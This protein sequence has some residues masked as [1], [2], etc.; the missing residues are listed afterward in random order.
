MNVSERHQ[1]RQNLLSRHTSYT[2][3]EAISVAC[4]VHQGAVS[5]N[6]LLTLKAVELQ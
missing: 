2:L 6:E 1:A 4:M 5:P 3:H